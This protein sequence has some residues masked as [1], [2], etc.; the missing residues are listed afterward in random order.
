MLSTEQAAVRAGVST[1]T[2]IRHMN[3]GAL[4]SYKIG[5]R[6]VIAEADLVAWI[7]SCKS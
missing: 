1:N 7:E 6:R 3:R 4:P 5:K 2:L